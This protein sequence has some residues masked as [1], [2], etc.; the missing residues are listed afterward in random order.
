MML[1]ALA[2]NP[3]RQRVSRD[4]TVPAPVEGWDASSPLAA[5]APTRAVQLT[6]WFPQ[7]GYLEV[8]RGSAYQSWDIGTDAITV[9][10]ID[11]GAD[12][13]TAAGHGFSD[14]DRVKIHASTTLPGGVSGSRLYYVINSATNTFELSKTDG[15]S[16]LDVTSAGSGTITAYSMETRPSVQSL[17]PYQGPSGVTKM[18][19]AAGAAIWDTSAKSYARFS[20]GGSFGSN[21]WQHA[22][23]ATSGGNFLFIVNGSDAPRYFD[24]SSWTTPTITGTGITASDFVTVT[25]HKFRLWFAIK[26]STDAAY[27]PTSSIAGT[28]VKFPLGPLFSKGGYLAATETWSADGGAGPDDYMVFISSRGQ[29]AVYS[30]TD[31]SSASTWALV[32]VFDVGEPIGRRCS[33]RYGTNPLIITDSGLMQL[34]MALSQDKAEMK[35]TAFTSRIYQAMTEAA[36]NYGANFGWQAIS[37]PRGNMLLLNVPTA[38]TSTS[39]QYV[40]NTLTGAWC[41]F[42]GWN[43]NCFALY[44]DRLYFAGNNGDV[45]QADIGSTDAGEQI[46]ATGQTAYRPFGTQGRNKRFTLLKALTRATSSN[47]PQLGVSTDFLETFSLS[48]LPA[49]QSSGALWDQAIWDESEWSGDDVPIS[50][51]ASTTAFGVWGSL[52][53]VASTGSSV[54]GL[55]WGV[56]LWGEDEWGGSTTDE[57]MQINGFVVVFEPGAY[58]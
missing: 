35:G 46:I 41:E 32:G 26:D 9:S 29:A 39:V 47:R 55:L 11:T 43:A 40:M 4:A 8:R 14:G 33:F 1:E 58:L 6:N 42:T 36:R 19:A 3:A 27:L 28:A 49:I 22:N 25:P 50:D 53:F 18:F 2:P 21:R 30:G 34:Q 12:E 5:M 15:G 31:P 37:Y 16:A 24:G 7:P 51:W 10:S 23:F 54:G 45:Y 57:V 44:N 17:M 52:K 48:T 38:E 20:T 13:F 56:A